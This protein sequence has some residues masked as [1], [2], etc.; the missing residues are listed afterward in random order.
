MLLSCQVVVVVVKLLFLSKNSSG[1]VST[2]FL[3]IGDYSLGEHMMTKPHRFAHQILSQEQISN[4]VEVSTDLG[5]PY[6]KG[7]SVVLHSDDAHRWTI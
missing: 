4:M 3:S 7:Q 1:N 6:G 2:S 5:A